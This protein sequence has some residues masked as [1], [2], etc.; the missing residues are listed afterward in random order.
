MT[1]VSDVVRGYYAAYE[2]KDRPA[3]EA[4]VG[5]DFTFSSPYDDHID[6][7]LYFQKCWPNSEHHARFH[8]EKLFENGNEAFVRYELRLKSGVTFRNTEF[9][10]LEGGKIREVEVYFGLQEGTVR[11][12]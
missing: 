6:R 1:K 11:K 9:L 7:A 4:L 5:D 8:I 12:P 3:I 10:R 2:Q